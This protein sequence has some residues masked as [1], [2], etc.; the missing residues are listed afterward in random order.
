MKKN[1]IKY[2]QDDAQEVAAIDV[3]LVEFDTWYSIRENNIPVHHRKEILKADFIARK[4]NMINS[5]EAFDD[6]LAK[7]GVKLS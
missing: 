4:V 6:A 5:M 7:Y 3:E 2:E 1:Q